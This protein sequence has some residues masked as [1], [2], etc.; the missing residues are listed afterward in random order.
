MNSFK[1][2][3]S[4]MAAALTLGVM[5]ALPTQAAVISPTLTID[6]ATATINA[7]ETATATVTLS[8]ISETSADTATILSATFSQPSG[9]SRSATLSLVETNTASVSIAANK[10]TADVNST[11]NTTGYVSAKFKLTLD[12][13]TVAGTYVVNVITTKPNPGPSVSWTV[14]V[15]APDLIASAATSTSILNNG[16]TTS[17]TTDATVFASK[18]VSSDAAAVVVLT[19]KNAAGG[20]ASE[21][22]TATITGAGSVGHGTNATTISMLGRSIVI[23]AGN[24]IG[25]FADGTAGVGTLT[26]T[27]QSGV[28]LA[29]EKVTF[30][31]DIASIE[32]TTVKSVLAVGSNAST[33][34]AVAKD[35][36]GVTVGAGTLYAYSDSLTVVSDTATAATIT[37]GVAT[38]AI[39]GVKTGTANIV[40]K[41]STGTIA[42]APTALRVEGSAATVKISFD[43]ATYAPGEAA[44]INIQVLDASGLPLSGKTHANLFTSTGI[45]STYAFGTGSDVLT[46]ASVTTA[47][48]TTVKAYKVFMPMAAGV[49]T[50]SATGGSSLP[51]AGQVAV[52]ASATVVDKSAQALD[53]VTALSAQIQ[54][55][56]IKINA[57]IITLTD[58]V[59][60]I[61]KKVKA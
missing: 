49:V 14:T 3:A 24:Y 15:K 9:A 30:Y 31:G 33:F 13:V 12:S 16:E 34:K 28:V 5:S 19:Q 21:S 46:S 55:F 29:T 6:A 42:S 35:A 18:T 7:G 11:T 43:K 20:S 41:N 26:L 37:D 50:L 2:L 1:K 47:D 8:Y 38:F 48:T 45:A 56:I 51:S 17:A 4:I 53:L 52:S 54:A 61:Q 59:M 23:P 22:I 32:V 40:V 44:T 36:S 60:K 57:Q 58:L 39:N 27:S 25:I 10:L